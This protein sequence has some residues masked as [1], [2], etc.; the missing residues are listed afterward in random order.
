MTTKTLTIGNELEI[1]HYRTVQKGYGRQGLYLDLCNKEGHD[2]IDHYVCDVFPNLAEHFDQY[3][4]RNDAFETDT[5]GVFTDHNGDREYTE[6]NMFDT[7]LDM[8][9]HAFEGTE[10]EVDEDEED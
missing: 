1:T 5:E 7:T 8:L 10:I 9:N 3:I 6:E 2:I 4:L